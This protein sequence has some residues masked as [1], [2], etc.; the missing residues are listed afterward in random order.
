MARIVINKHTLWADEKYENFLDKRALSDISE[1]YL[2]IINSKQG[3][4][5]V[6]PDAYTAGIIFSTEVNLVFSHRSK[7]R[8]VLNIFAF[9]FCNIY[10]CPL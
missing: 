6:I 8:F 5:N 2:F 9:F 1:L 4:E 10:I 3:Y 7:S